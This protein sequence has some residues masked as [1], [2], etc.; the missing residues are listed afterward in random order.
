MWDE[1]SRAKPL[2][3]SRPEENRE[4]EKSRELVLFSCFCMDL[5]DPELHSPKHLQSEEEPAHD[6][7]LTTHLVCGMCLPRTSR[8]LRSRLQT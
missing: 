7:R 4:P 5:G 8:K 6:V 3:A 1:G 2:Q